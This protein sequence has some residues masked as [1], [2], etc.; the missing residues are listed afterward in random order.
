LVRPFSKEAVRQLRQ[1]HPEVDLAYDLVQQFAQ[2]L[3]TCTGEQLD[4]WLE[5]VRAR[6][7]REFQSFVLVIE[8]DKAAV[9]AGLASP[10]CASAF[11]T[12]CKTKGIL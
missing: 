12:P 3:R 4:V 5:K 10:S 7:V 9:T 11:S 8:R 6:Q 1:S 2:M